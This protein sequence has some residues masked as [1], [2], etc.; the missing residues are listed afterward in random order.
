M[1]LGDRGGN[2]RSLEEARALFRTHKA[3]LTHAIEQDILEHL[4]THDEWHADDLTVEIPADSP[5]ALGSV[6]GR[7]VKTGALVEVGRRASKRVA[8]HSRKS[9][10]YRRGSVGGSEG[11]SEQAS[12]SAAANTASDPD[13]EVLRLFDPPAA[14]HYDESEAA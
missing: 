7:L 9:G 8:A 3:E 6:V 13:S 11:A 10:V 2:T 1:S 12:S 14:G 5:N 4:D